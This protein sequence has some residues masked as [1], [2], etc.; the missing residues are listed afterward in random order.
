MPF[1]FGENMSNNIKS[2]YGLL[3]EMYENLSIDSDFPS[4]IEWGMA[5]NIDGKFFDWYLLDFQ[6]HKKPYITIKNK[7][8]NKKL[9]LNNLELKVNDK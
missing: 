1:L 4:F 5:N 8:K 9:S 3:K 7:N 2:V 6:K